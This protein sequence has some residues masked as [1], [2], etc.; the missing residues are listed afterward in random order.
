[1]F[2]LNKYINQSKFQNESS[3]ISENE[4]T[5]LTYWKSNLNQTRNIE[6]ISQNVKNIQ[7]NRGRNKSEISSNRVNTGSYQTN[8]YTKD[9]NIKKL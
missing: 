8:K 6:G 2:I 1:M 4:N 3:P 9:I 5:S 7:Q